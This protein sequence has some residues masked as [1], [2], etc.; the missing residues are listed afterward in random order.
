M[1]MHLCDD[2]STHFFRFAISSFFFLVGEVEVHLAYSFLFTLSQSITFRMFIQ[3]LTIFFDSI[4]II[5]HCYSHSISALNGPSLNLERG[6]I[7][8][9]LV[10]LITLTLHIVSSYLIRVAF[11]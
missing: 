4:H 8:H 9:R 3:L 2:N 10:L 5:P 6:T 1:V 11:L 7:A